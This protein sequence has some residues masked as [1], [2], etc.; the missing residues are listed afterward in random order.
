MS[1]HELRATFALHEKPIPKLIHEHETDI[2]N[3]SSE[4]VSSAVVRVVLLGG[5]KIL[6]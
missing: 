6:I 4:N 5:T 3:D 1:L 2:K